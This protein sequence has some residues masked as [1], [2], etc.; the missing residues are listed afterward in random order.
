MDIVDLAIIIIK[1]FYNRKYKPIYF[2]LS[3]EV[4]LRLYR[5]YSILVEPNKK[6]RR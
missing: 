2:K 3:D 5:G 1:H 4:Y 6:L